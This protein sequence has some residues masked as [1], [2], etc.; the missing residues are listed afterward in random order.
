[1]PHYC[2]KCKINWAALYREDDTAG[3]ESYDFCPVCKTDMFL[4]DGLQGDS[5]ILVPGGSIINPL[6][7]QPLQLPVKKNYMPEA[8]A[9]DI[10]AYKQRMENN[11]AI[12]DQAINAYTQLYDVMGRAAAEAEF[13]NILKTQ[14]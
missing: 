12:Q 7:H 5:Y 8:P 6:N 2:T 14:S 9:F 1:M 11:E 13:F 4:A 3:D 10:Q